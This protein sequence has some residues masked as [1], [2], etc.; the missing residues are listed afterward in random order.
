[1][2]TFTTLK[3]NLKYG[4]LIPRYQEWMIEIT[5][6]CLNPRHF[7]FCPNETFKCLNLLEHQSSFPVT[8]VIIV[9]FVH[10]GNC[11]PYSF[12]IFGFMYV[13]LHL[14][15]SH[16]SIFCLAYI[17]IGC[18]SPLSRMQCTAYVMIFNDL[19]IWFIVLNATVS[20]ISAL[21][22]RPVLVVEE[23]GVPGENHRPWT[24]NW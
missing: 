13:F 11:L 10:L 3:P 4:L 5:I 14:L 15:S 23:A 19:K 8:D 24:S 9:R 2:S 6:A 7:R 17:C 16:L 1:M 12:L 20:N 18:T 21:S 22:W